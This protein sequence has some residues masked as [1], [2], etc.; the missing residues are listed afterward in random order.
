MGCSEEIIIQA[1]SLLYSRGLLQ[2]GNIHCRHPFYE[3]FID[4]TRINKNIDE[5]MDKINNEKI[6][7]ISSNKKNNIYTEN[8]NIVQEIDNSS[9]ILIEIYGEREIKSYQHTIEEIY[10]KNTPI[11]IV[12]FSHNKMFIFFVEKNFSLSF[13][14]VRKFIY[15]D[16]NT[17]KIDEISE[18]QVELFRSYYLNI[19]YNFIGRIENLY[20][21]NGYIYSLDSDFNSEIIKLSENYSHE[22]YEN[23]YFRLE[24]MFNFP[25]KKYIGVKDHQNHYNPVNLDLANEQKTYPSNPAYSVESMNNEIFKELLFHTCGFKEKIPGFNRVYRNNP[26]GGN[27]GSVSLYF[28]NLKENQGIDCGIYYYNPENNTIVL[29]S[30]FT[31]E[32]WKKF[33]HINHDYLIIFIGEYKKVMKKYG[34]FGYKITNL[35]AGVA[36][37]NLLLSA[38]K[39]NV[40][41]KEIFDNSNISTITTYLKERNTIITKLIGVN[42]NH[43]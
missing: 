24:N 11:F 37:A 30:K 15:D 10:E 7:I 31:N 13:N 29:I 8:F 19:I 23:I 4:N 12:Y 5:A 2:E 34:D 26:T 9:T 42:F 40:T 6:F 32:M 20:L 16:I 28:I 27:L 39:N 1:I 41:I 43:D 3:K 35:D 14:D 21:A 22:L 36:F 25:P 38:H 18:T 17:G 33:E